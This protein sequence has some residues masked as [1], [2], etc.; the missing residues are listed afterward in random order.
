MDD[1]RFLSADYTDLQSPRIAVSGLL[2]LP[3]LRNLWRVLRMTT[4]DLTFSQLCQDLFRNRFQ[5]VKHSR[6]SGGYGLD[7]W[8]SFA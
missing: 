5:C 4:I 8:F 1:D 3:Y 7:Y 2:S 6:A